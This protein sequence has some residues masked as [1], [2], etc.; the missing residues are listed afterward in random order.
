MNRALYM[1]EYMRR[2]RTETDTVNT[3]PICGCSFTARRGARF[4]SPKCRL[5]AHRETLTINTPRLAVAWRYLMADNYGAGTVINQAGPIDQ[6][7]VETS[8]REQFGRKL[9]ELEPCE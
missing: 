7:S 1:R 8:L 5:K 2:R 9:I 6:T 4:C 3:C